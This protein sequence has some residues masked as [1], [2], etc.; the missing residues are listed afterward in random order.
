MSGDLVFTHDFQDF[1]FHGYVELGGYWPKL[2][3]VLYLNPAPYWT[4][5]A[6][7]DELR[8]YIDRVNKF[9]SLFNM[10]YP[11]WAE[12]WISTHRQMN[13][14]IGYLVHLAKTA[15]QLHLQ[16]VSD[17]LMN[18]V[19]IANAWK[20]SYHRTRDRVHK[21]LRL[22]IASLREELLNLGFVINLNR[23]TRIVVERLGYEGELHYAIE[24]EK[25]TRGISEAEFYAILRKHLTR[26][27]RHK[28]QFSELKAFWSSLGR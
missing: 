22:R 7:L 14:A 17:V 28:H 1:V 4:T 6:M 23:E 8:N 27:N 9:V 13:H 18:A 25:Y 15:E 26:A 12:K 5:D 3:I 16:P 19:K 20:D 24:R 21:L 11:L 10:V 2:K